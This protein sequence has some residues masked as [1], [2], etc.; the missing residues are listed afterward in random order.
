MNDSVLSYRYSLRRTIEGD[1]EPV[2]RMY[3]VMLNPSTA[4]DTEDDPTI[5]RCMWFARREGC[6][7]LHVVNLFPVRATKPSDLM[8]MA[9]RAALLGEPGSVWVSPLVQ[10]V[11]ESNVLVVA[12]GAAVPILREP[13]VNQFRR[14]LGRRLAM[15]LGR[16]KDGSPR[17]PLYVRSDQPL[18]PWS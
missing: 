6:G 10:A 14:V 17:H 8:K 7:E 5:R 11:Y 1:V 13:Q 2:S 12:W 9:A 4:T 18:E 3:F 15:C 16:T